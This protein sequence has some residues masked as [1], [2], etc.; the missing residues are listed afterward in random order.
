[1]TVGVA[2]KCLALAY[3]NPSLLFLASEQCARKA[4]FS[5]QN[6][7]IYILLAG[8]RNRL[9]VFVMKYGMDKEQGSRHMGFMLAACARS[10][11]LLVAKSVLFL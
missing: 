8:L 11:K 10:R 5:L 7:I 9:L 1:M 2:G 4:V 3:L 6:I